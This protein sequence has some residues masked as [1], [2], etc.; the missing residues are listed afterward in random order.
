MRKDTL[1][2]KAIEGLPTREQLEE[3]SKKYCNGEVNYAF[4]LGML[5]AATD[6]VKEML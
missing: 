6:I 2:K 5:L 3:D 4:M 1:L